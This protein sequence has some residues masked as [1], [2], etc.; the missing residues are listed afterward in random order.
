V[1]LREG[2]NDT[3]TGWKGGIEEKLKEKGTERVN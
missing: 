2:R 1:R 3:G